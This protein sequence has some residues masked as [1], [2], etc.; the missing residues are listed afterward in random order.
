MQRL[1][2]LTVPDTHTHIQYIDYPQVYTIY[3]LA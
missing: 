1:S 2:V 3:K